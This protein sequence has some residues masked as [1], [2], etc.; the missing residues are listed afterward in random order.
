MTRDGFNQE[1]VT[2]THDSMSPALSKNNKLAFVKIERNGSHNIYTRD[3]HSENTEKLTSYTDK[4]A[5]SP[6]F[7]PDG[8]KLLFTVSDAENTDLYLMD[9][10]S[11]KQ[12]QL[13]FDGKSHSPSY[14]YQGDRIIFSSFIIDRYQPE[15]FTM[16]TDRSERSKLTSDGGV[17]PRWYFRILDAPLPT[18]VVDAPRPV[19]EA[20]AQRELPEEY[21]APQ[22]APAEA[23]PAPIT[24]AVPYTG[25]DLSI[26]IIKDGNRLIF[27]PVIHFASGYANIRPEFYPI[28]DDM[29]KTSA[30]FTSPIVIL[31]HTDNVPINTRQYPDNTVLSA[32][33][34]EAVKNYLVNNHRIPAS[35][36]QTEAHGESK[37]IVPNDTPENRYKNRRAEIQILIVPAE[38]A[39]AQELTAPPAPVPAVPAPDVEAVPAPVEEQ[40]TAPVP[41]P[42]PKPKNFFQR[43]LSSKKKQSAG[44]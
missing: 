15:L 31:G 19:E 26:K 25:D 35:R 41:T 23:F 3:L 8:T 12:E 5:G 29:M 2:D 14:S 30:K 16:R 33:R 22:E 21:T 18:P 17:S 27:Y 32:A 40:E 43:L 1:A 28:I 42:T 34:A 9:L 6:V 24:A 4:Q 7:S 37:P 39:L 38:D 44:W 10:A 20:L 36:I 11:R 13:T